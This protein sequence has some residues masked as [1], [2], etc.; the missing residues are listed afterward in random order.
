[1]PALRSGTETHPGEDVSE[2]RFVAKEVAEL[3][4]EWSDRVEVR[5]IYSTASFRADADLM[6]WWVARSAEDVQDLLVALRRTRLGRALMQTHAFLGLVRPAEFA[7]DHIPAFVRGLAPKRFACVY[8]FVRT[9]EWYLLDSRE[10]GEYLRSHGELGREYPD[11]VPNTTSAFGLGD[12]EWIL[13]FEADALDR[14]VDL[15]RHLRA[16][17]SRRYVKEEVPFI[18]GIRKDLEAALNDLPW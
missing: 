17:E 3:L 13:A 6:L 2:R 9:P 7:P 12:Y 8:P 10:R 11:V 5:G 15:I 1:L 16:N 14:L 4:R 18:T